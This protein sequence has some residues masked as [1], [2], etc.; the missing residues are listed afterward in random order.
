[1]RTYQPLLF[2]E[3]FIFLEAPRWRDNR[4]WVSDV[5][6]HTVYVLGLNGVRESLHCAAS[7]F[8]P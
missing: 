5:F 7:A 1:M 3:D 2:A 6:D 4:L 8:R